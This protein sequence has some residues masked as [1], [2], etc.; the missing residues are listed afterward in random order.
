M[1]IGAEEFVQVPET[2]ERCTYAGQMNTERPQK[3]E[4]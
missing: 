4:L 1:D 2:G 3:L